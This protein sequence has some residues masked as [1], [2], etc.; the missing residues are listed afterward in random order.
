MLLA[1]AWVLHVREL[2]VVS[3]LASAQQPWGSLA[4]HH[5]DEKVNWK[6]FMSPVK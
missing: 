4:G 5:S 3:A 6:Y 1:E 2:V